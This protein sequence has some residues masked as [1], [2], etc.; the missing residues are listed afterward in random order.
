MVAVSRLASGSPAGS[1]VRKVFK[2]G[3]GH[4]G[5]SPTSSEDVAIAVP[6]PSAAS[7]LDGIRVPVEPNG[8]GGWSTESGFEASVRD[9]VW[10][11]P[12]TTAGSLLAQT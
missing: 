8:F 4:A 1:S 3:E 11:L 5:E 9:I 6:A 10:R 2:K 12:S 7:S